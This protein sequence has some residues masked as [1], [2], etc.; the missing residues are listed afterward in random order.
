MENYD[1][2]IDAEVTKLKDHVGFLSTNPT[3]MF[4]IT[5]WEYLKLLCVARKI[6]TE[7]F[8]EQNIFELLLQQYAATYSK[9]MKK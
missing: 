4:R 5:G 1:G 8:E 6:K 7:N 3:F 9:G 2:R